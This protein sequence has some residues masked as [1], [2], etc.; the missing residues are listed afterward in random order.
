LQGKATEAEATL[1]ALTQRADSEPR[2]DINLALVYGV[3]GK[4]GQAQPLLEKYFSQDQVASTLQ[5]YQDY[6]LLNAEQR[7]RVVY[8]FSENPERNPKSDS[9]AGSLKAF[10][11]PRPSGTEKPDASKP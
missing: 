9:A 6:T 1:K 5:F 10:L 7:R 4:S 2:F 3:S 11:S 8:G